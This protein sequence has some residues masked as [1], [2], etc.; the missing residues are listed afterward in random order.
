MGGGHSFYL[1]EIEAAMSIELGMTLC[2]VRHASVDSY[3]T[4]VMDGVR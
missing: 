3:M 4:D 1:G 2:V